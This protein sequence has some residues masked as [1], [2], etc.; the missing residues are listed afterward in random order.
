[1]VNSRNKG[2]IEEFENIEF[3]GRIPK[4]YIVTVTN[5]RL[6]FNIKQTFAEHFDRH[7]LLYEICYGAT[8]HLFGIV[9]EDKPE[10]ADRRLY[11]RAL[12]FISNC[13]TED[14]TRYA[15]SKAK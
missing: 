14:R 13:Q 1:M 3:R 5:S 15:S 6:C 2:T 11:E 8:K 9:D 4:S 12:E 10:E 7:Y